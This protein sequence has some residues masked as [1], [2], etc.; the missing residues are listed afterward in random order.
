MTGGG[1][2]TYLQVVGGVP[3]LRIFLNSHSH[4]AFKNNLRIN[5][6]AEVKSHIHMLID[7]K[8]NT[9]LLLQVPA[10]MLNSLMFLMTCDKTFIVR[11][12]SI[13]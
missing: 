6:S 8:L 10:G 5:F 12:T 11:Y 13:N 9:R 4:I 2:V 1:L 7:Y 3:T